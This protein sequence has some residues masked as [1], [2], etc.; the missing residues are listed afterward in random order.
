MI[1]FTVDAIMRVFE[2]LYIFEFSYMS[3]SS[4][5]RNFTILKM[6]QDKSC[7]RLGKFIMGHLLKK[8]TG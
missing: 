3:Y 4:I 5:Q 1:G 8:R 7:S 2:V 6:F